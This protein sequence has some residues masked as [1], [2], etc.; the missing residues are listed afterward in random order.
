MR[1]ILA[2]FNVATVIVIL[3]LLVSVMFVPKAVD[4]DLH[5]IGGADGPTAVWLTT[6]KLDFFAYAIPLYF[7]I[8][9]L[10]NSYVLLWKSDNKG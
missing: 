3:A 2:L 10:T 7:C 1:K 6:A 4:S 5:V 9:L 8:L